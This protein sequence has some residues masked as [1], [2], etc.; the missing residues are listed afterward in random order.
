MSLIIESFIRLLD[1]YIPL[2]NFFF[3]H[4]FYLIGRVLCEGIE[5]TS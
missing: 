2:F 1:R 4:T 5:K 3:L